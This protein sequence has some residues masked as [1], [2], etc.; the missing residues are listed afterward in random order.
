[1]TNYTKITDNDYAS[2]ALYDKV[3]DM[4][5]ALNA[6]KLE[7][8]AAG[9]RKA[10]TTYAVSN[11]VMCEY[12]PDLLLV[13][14]TAGTTAVGALD[15][16]GA[17]NPGDTITDGSVVWTA[18][19]L[20]DLTDVVH[21]SLTETI[22]GNKTFSGDV[23][24][25]SN[26]SA[27]PTSY[28]NSSNLLATTSM[29]HDLNNT[30]RT[31]CLT[32]IP[33]DIKL[34]LNNSTITLKAGSKLY[35]PN[36]FEQD[37]TTLKYNAITIS[38]DISFTYSTAQTGNWFVVYEP[39]YNAIG[40]Y[41]VGQVTSG[42]TPPS[43]GLFYNTSDNSIKF[44]SSSI[45][46]ST[47]IPFPL[48]I[49]SLQTTSPY[50]KSIDQVFNGLG[51][52]GS[53]I[54]ALPGVKGLIPNGRNADG[55]LKNTEFVTNNVLINT[56]GNST[57]NMYVLLNGTGISCLD[58]SNIEYKEKEN[59]VYNTAQSWA[60]YSCICSD[61]YRTSGKITSLN[62]KTAFHAVDYNDIANNDFVIDWQLPSSS[63]NY[64]WYR[65]YRS[66]WVEQGQKSYLL[67]QS[68]TTAITLPVPMSNTDYTGM[69]CGS[70]TTFASASTLAIMA[71]SST[72]VNLWNFN[73]AASMSINWEVK[74]QAAS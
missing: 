74:G 51:Y 43:S 27:T 32:E 13:C 17:L 5:D 60:E 29:V 72:Q 44:Y 54:F 16:S 39:T 68:T 28:A 47:G 66:G 69:I 9:V 49:V 71:K 70:N 57:S 12:H 36:G 22:T 45:A 34:E 3:N 11:V 33:Q 62:P 65:K 59:L 50:I 35:A 30:Q 38:N 26:A 42:T 21:K 18:V 14:T 63:N 41:L 15:T 37:G 64:T 20:A 1:M 24:L 52:I 40:L 55:T 7:R 23:S 67:A 2:G 10:S 61:L 56:V 19:R 73:T 6:G 48:G 4:V 58:T 25:G 8:A 31:N 53:T 46:L